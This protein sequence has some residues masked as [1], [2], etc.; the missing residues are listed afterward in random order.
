VGANGSAVPQRRIENS[1]RNERARRN[2]TLPRPG[3]DIIEFEGGK[4]S[5]RDAHG[6]RL[7]HSS[8]SSHCCVRRFDF[9]GMSPLCSHSAQAGALAETIHLSAPSVTGVQAPHTS[10]SQTLHLIRNLFLPPLRSHPTITR[11]LMPKF[12]Q[13]GPSSSEHARLHCGFTN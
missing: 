7:S 10:W 6:D 3:R 13:R 12:F 8:C 11:K 1:Q 9:P 5:D 4:G 2:E